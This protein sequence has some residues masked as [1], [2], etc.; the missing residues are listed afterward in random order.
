MFSIQVTVY[1]ALS[2]HATP[3]RSSASTPVHI[4]THDR[5]TINVHI[6]FA[7]G[8]GPQGIPPP[9][10]LISQHRSIGTYINYIY[11]S[12]MSPAPPVEKQCTVVE[13]FPRNI[14]T[15]GI[16]T[17]SCLVPGQTCSVEMFVYLQGFR[18][19]IFWGLTNGLWNAYISTSTVHKH[20]D[21]FTYLSTDHCILK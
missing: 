19:R 2:T 11:N 9:F 3:L 5:R 7:S 18:Y 6:S 21:S 14:S 13:F 4:C 16:Y 8:N 1:S 12:D 17:W 20:T 10:S 15:H